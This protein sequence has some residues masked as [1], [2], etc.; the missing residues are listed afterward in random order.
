MEKNKEVNIE[1]LSEDS[2]LQSIEAMIGIAAPLCAVIEDA[3]DDMI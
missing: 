1:S 2:V 3:S